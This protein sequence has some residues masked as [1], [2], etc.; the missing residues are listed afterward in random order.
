M[1]RYVLR[2]LLVSALLVLGLLSAVF[3]CARL[4]PGDP[5][6]RALTEDA[7]PRVVAEMRRQLGL[8]RPL[9]LQYVQWLADFVRGDL[10]T[11]FASRRP[12][13]E[14]VR[15]ALPNT[16]LLVGLALVL[17]FGLG[18]VIGTFAAVRHGQWADHVLMLAALVLYSM[19]AFW[20]GVVLQLVFAF[21]LQWLPAE[22]MHALDA[23]AMAPLARAWDGVRHL[24]LPV[25]VLAAGGIA[26][27]ARYTRA[28]LLET[29]S[30]EYVRA[31]RA[32]GLG[33]RSI[34][35]RHALRNALTPVATLLGLSLPALVGGALLVETIFSWPGMGRLAML[36]VATRDYPVIQATT[37]LSAVL[38]VGGSLLA[39]LLCARLDPRYRLQ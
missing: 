36:A 26:S 11:S 12:V 38:V 18:V 15:A 21:K 30:Q 8:D 17:R 29:L 10:G 2:R 22:S 35:L 13:A 4:L 1:L 5:L 14:L 16:F 19:P 24:V 20:L 31:A 34:V 3:F 32:R 28:S 39:D 33:E 6:G 37:A 7:D 9:A 25:T 23:T 27:T